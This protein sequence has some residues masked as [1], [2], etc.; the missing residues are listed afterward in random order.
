MKKKLYLENFF[1]GSS[2]K[3][4][5]TDICA[6]GESGKEI[7]AQNV[8]CYRRLSFPLKKNLI[9]TV[10]I[11]TPQAV[12][13]LCSKGINFYGSLFVN[14]VFI[15]LAKS[16]HVSDLM[17]TLAEIKR[18]PI[19]ASAFDEYYLESSFKGYIRE[20]V[21]KK[22]SIHGVV[23]ETGG[24]GILIAGASG[25]GKTTAA[26]E[27]VQKEG[28]WIADD[29]AVIRKNIQGELIARGHVKI[30]KYLYYGKEGIIPVEK[31]LATGKIK[32]ET[33]LS[34]IINVERT[35][36]KGNVFSETKNKILDTALPCLN[37]NISASGYFNENL[38]EKTTRKL[39]KVYQ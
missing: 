16:Q 33:K 17:K 1:R 19:A 39:K 18:I 22:T 32:K 29:L 35:D 13:Q 20:R 4:G 36:I 14:I 11:I 24:M 27:Y 25:I 9:P 21:Q 34:A 26:L 8:R 7:S 37:I 28:F 2:E 31:M 6:T 10:A 12:N 3:L 38:L 15:V 23:I 5:L 30:K